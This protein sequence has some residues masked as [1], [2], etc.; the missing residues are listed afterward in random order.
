MIVLF[1]MV[2]MTGWTALFILPGPNV[3]SLD[4][5]EGEVDLRNADLDDTVYSFGENWETYPE[6]IYAPEDIEDST[7]RKSARNITGDESEIY[8]NMDYATHVAD[9]KLIPDRSY[10][11]NMR[12]ADY[13]MRIFID[14]KF[15]DS[16]GNPSESEEKNVPRVSEKTYY[17]TPG[18]DSVQIV[19]QVSNYVHH[20][21]SYPPVFT[22][23]YDYNVTENMTHGTIVSF[24]LIGALFTAFLYNLGMFVLNSRKKEVFY[25]ALCC[26]LLMLMTNKLIPVYWPEYNWF[27][28]IRV[29]YIVHFTTFIVFTLF[30]IT[31]FPNMLNKMVVYAYIGISLIYILAVLMLQPKVF[32]GLIIYFDI[33]FVLMMI[34]LLAILAISLRGKKRKNLLAFVG[35][36]V[37][38]IAGIYDILYKNDLIPSLGIPGQN[39]IT[40]VA[41]LFL[42]FCFSLIISADYA[43]RDKT[44]AAINEQIADAE[45][46]YSKL[47]AANEKMKPATKLS[48]LGLSKRE[49]DV[50]YLLI[51]GRMRLEI[52]DMLGISIGSVNTYC[53]RIYHKADCNSLSEFLKK[54]GLPDKILEYIEEDKSG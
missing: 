15:V 11:I 16:V 53:S 28:A 4:Y 41:M 34:Y 9:L 7:V 1:L 20:E 50:A 6:K 39:F 51:D 44:I 38:D 54:L 45:I 27:V 25:F 37:L 35:M 8:E 32:T 24:L 19:V 2:V 43:E 29:E 42:V 3:V 17:F 13:A 36:L 18:K 52:A 14:G 26:L 31:L 48:D 23:G 10:G 40:P 5:Q 22:I 30:F 21:G 46:R 49:R 12:S 33:I 47:L